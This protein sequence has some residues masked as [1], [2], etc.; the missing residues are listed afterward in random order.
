[1]IKSIRDFLHSPLIKVLERK[2]ILDAVGETIST[3]A[4][5]KVPLEDIQIQN[6]TLY[7]QVKPIVKSELLLHIGEIIEILE[8]K[9]PKLGIRDIR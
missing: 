4:K 8:Q 9:A 3:Y 6:A 2:K 1:M 7:V 5:V